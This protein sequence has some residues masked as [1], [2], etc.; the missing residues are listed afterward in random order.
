MQIANR[1]HLILPWKIFFQNC[2]MEIRSVKLKMQRKV[3]MLQ[4]LQQ[5]Y[6]QTH[7]CNSLQWLSASKLY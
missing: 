3:L 7:N 4:K 6:T 2:Q 5:K 1:R